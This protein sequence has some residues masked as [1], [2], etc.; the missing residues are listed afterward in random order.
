MQRSTI[1]TTIQQSIAANAT[2]PTDQLHQ[3]NSHNRTVN[4]MLQ[5]PIEATIQL[6]RAAAL[7][8]QLDESNHSSQRLCQSTSC[9][10][11]KQAQQQHNEQQLS[12]AMQH[13]NAARIHQFD[14]NGQSRSRAVQHSC[15]TRSQPCRHGS[16]ATRVA[17]SPSNLMQSRH[18]AA[19]A[20]RESFARITRALAAPD[21]LS[22]T[23]SMQ[24]LVAAG[25][26]HFFSLNG[27]N[28]T[29][30]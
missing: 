2:T 14:C 25:S 15:E 30:R 1:K 19:A 21:Q 6:C 24:S 12:R 10:L 13:C 29:L 7:C 22:A 28:K 20:G 5:H 11:N 3:L 23:S 9:R 17:H 16:R 8:K 18:V 4:P 27:E 26:R